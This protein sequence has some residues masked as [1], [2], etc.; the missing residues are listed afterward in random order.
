MLGESAILEYDQQRRATCKVTLTDRNP[1]AAADDACRDALARIL[2]SDRF[3]RAE[4]LKDFLTYIVEETLAGRGE[5]IRGKTIAMDVYGRDP[6]SSGRSENVVRVD[7]RRLR[8]SL[9]DYYAG[10]GKN[11]AVRICVD[12]GGYVPRMEMRKDEVPKKPVTWVGRFPNR[13]ILVALGIGLAAL[14]Y[15]G[16]SF[17]RP[18]PGQ[19]PQI[20]L[21]RQALRNKSAATLQAA[22]LAEQARGFLFPLLEPERQRIATDMFRQ[23]IRLDPD[24]FG[25]YAGAAQTLTTLS[26]LKPPGPER[27]ETRTEALRMAKI[28]LEKNPT[29]PWVQSA[30]GWAAFGNGE[31]ERAIE[32]SHRAARLSPQDGYIL[33][34]HALISLLTGHFEEARKASNPSRPRKFA[35]RRLAN[36]NFFGVASFHL[37]KNQEAIASFQKAAELGDP[38]SAL[39]LMYQAAA[40]QASG[41][42]G[43]ASELVREMVATWPDYHPE[44]ALPEFYQHP[45]HVDQILDQLRAAGWH[46]GN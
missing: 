33:D 16:F 44:L 7:A 22:N 11:D 5:L 27:D 41:N 42:S 3:V 28:A 37:G 29:N 23:A 10:E 20:V 15:L 26:K 13:V 8:R 31:F 17:S 9:V 19:D 43:R 32:F 40:Y 6:S 30:A 12:S 35:K 18:V 14:L 36:R 46:P 21:E 24:Y 2:A 25:G 38:I 39:S 4:R 34:F 45:E 1:T